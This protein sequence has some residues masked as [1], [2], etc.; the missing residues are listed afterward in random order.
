MQWGSKREILIAENA[1]MHK[2]IEMLRERLEEK[3][4]EIVDLRAQLKNTQ[5][6]LVAKQSPDAYREQKLAEY[7][8]NMPEP[9]EEQ[10]EAARVQR[11]RA[12][13][14]GN[15]ISEMEAP[16]FKDRDDM[17]S[18]LTKRVGAPLSDSP[19]LHGNDE[20]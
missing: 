6:A 18:L 17:I 14:A 15:Y 2:E 5:E 16:L 1:V 19:S 20:S 11:I 4:Q 12:E 8:A 7:E 10:K 3:Q 9:T 13:A